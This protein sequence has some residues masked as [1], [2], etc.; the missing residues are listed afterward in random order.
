MKGMGVLSYDREEKKYLYF[1]FDNM[2]MSEKADGTVENDV[3][4]YTNESKMN[5]KPSRPVTKG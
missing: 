4:T 2:G 3:W 5:G 1:G